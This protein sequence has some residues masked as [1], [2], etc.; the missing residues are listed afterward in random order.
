MDKV[1]KYQAIIKQLLHEQANILV[2]TQPRI[3]YQVIS[4]TEN[5]HFQLVMTGWDAKDHFVYA[6]LFHFDIKPNGKIWI[7]VNNTDVLIGEELVEHGVLKSDIVLGFHSEM[8]R[9]YTGYAVA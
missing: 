5:N 3:E 9:P 2:P 4:D 7:L 6:V 1:K 8:V